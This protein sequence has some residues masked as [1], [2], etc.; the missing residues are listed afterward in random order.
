MIFFSFFT[1]PSFPIFESSLLLISV[2][3]EVI[4]ITM[5]LIRFQVQL[6]GLRENKHLLPSRQSSYLPNSLIYP[7]ILKQCMMCSRSTGMSVQ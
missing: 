4:R 6:C 7:Q 1:H 2:L 3:D 5:A